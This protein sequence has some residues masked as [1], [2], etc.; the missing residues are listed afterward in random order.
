MKMIVASIQAK[1]MGTA[2][3]R[4]GG[5]GLVVLLDTRRVVSRDVALWGEK[6]HGTLRRELERETI[7]ILC[8]KSLTSARLP[9]RPRCV[10]GTTRGA[11]R[12][13]QA[14]TT[15]VHNARR[16]DVRVHT[17]CKNGSCEIAQ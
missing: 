2:A 8:A 12:V 15:R 11:S 3:L 14:H 7:Q 17:R 1:S 6:Q 10:L 5:G 4:K 9:L 16:A 13:K